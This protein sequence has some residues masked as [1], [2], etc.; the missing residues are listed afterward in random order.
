MATEVDRANRAAWG[1]GRVVDLL[2]GRE[3]FMSE[4]ERLVME[5]VAREARG[6]PIL[7]IGVGGGRTTSFL[8]SVSTDYVGI[9]YLE[10]LVLAAR[11][12]YPD[13]RFEHMDARD[14]S[15][16]A[17]ARFALVVFSLNGI[18]GVPHADRATILSEVHRILRPGGLF[19][20]CTHNLDYRPSAGRPRQWEWQTI[21]REPARAFRYVLRLPKSSWQR[22][23]LS[24]MSARGDGW[25]SVATLAYGR[26]VIWHHITLPESLR[27]LRRAA[28]TAE[29]QVYSSSGFATTIS[30]ASAP[31]PPLLKSLDTSEWPFIHLVARKP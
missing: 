23:R 27:E 6:Q 13:A 2:L 18:D 21:V 4:G 24:D 30:S 22:H 12:R 14:L 26:P 29:V 7:D 20:Y 17:D 11:S 5:R 3:G 19:A 9:D 16:F 1:S 25:A 8:R 31:D 15:S 10:E 28:F